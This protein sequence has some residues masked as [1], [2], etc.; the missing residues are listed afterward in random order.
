MP[1]TTTTTM[2]MQDEEIDTQSRSQGITNMY[3]T[4]PQDDRKFQF[5]IKSG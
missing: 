2:P 1:P 3:G 5:I 4:P